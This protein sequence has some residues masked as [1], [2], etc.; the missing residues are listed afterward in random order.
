MAQASAELLDGDDD[1]VAGGDYSGTFVVSAPTLP[2][3]GVADFA[4]GNAQAVD[5]PAMASGLPIHLSDGTGIESIAF[6]LRL[7]HDAASPDTDPMRV[8]AI[9]LAPGLPGGATLAY[10]LTDPSVISVSA[11]LPAGSTFGAGARSLVIVRASVGA[12]AIYGDKQVIDIGD[13]VVNG[14]P[15]GAIDDDGMQV[16]ALFGDTSGDRDYGTVDVQRLQRVIVRHDTGFAAHPNA[17]PIII[18]DINGNGSFSALDVTR[19]LQEVN[20]V[21]GGLATDRPEIP[22]IP[23][24]VNPLALVGPDPTV[25]L[26]RDLRAKPGDTIVVPL[27]LDTAEGLDSVRVR[28][29]WDAQALELLAVNRGSMTGDFQW[30]IARH[31]E[32]ELYVDM[33]RLHA[34]AGGTGSLLELRFRIAADAQPGV[35][36]LDLTWVSLNEGRLTLTP[37]PQPGPDAADGLLTI[38]GD[39]PAVPVVS[40]AAPVVSDAA[41]V[42]SNAAPVVSDAASTSDAA[43]VQTLPV[44]TPQPIA[45]TTPTPTAPA[46]DAQAPNDSAAPQPAPVAASSKSIRPIIVVP[47]PVEASGSGLL[48][49]VG[50]ALQRKVLVS[51]S[52][53]ELAADVAAILPAVAMPPSWDA[54]QAPLRLGLTGSTAAGDWSTTPVQP[55]HDWLHGFVSGES[56]RRADANAQLKV[57]L[58]RV[59]PQLAAGGGIVKAAARR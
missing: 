30:Y 3:L 7:R 49:R 51:I 44:E 29:A 4:R 6:T 42:V 12:D 11:T 20:F 36:D 38:E 17:D 25:D 23:S 31:G 22:A 13:I 24:G 14:T 16:V 8:S 1:D 56:S 50:Q 41:S 58:P 54:V 21:V 45:S 10:D 46:S 52:P 2:V 32:G 43:P 34:L 57:T 9:E 48:G 39:A 18:A 5:I 35:A 53:A 37:L 28:L 40:D 19:I 15:G 27:R 55:A 33:S 26:P 59:A 47:A